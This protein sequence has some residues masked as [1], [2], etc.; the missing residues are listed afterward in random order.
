MSILRTMELFE[1][2]VI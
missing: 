2:L 1:V